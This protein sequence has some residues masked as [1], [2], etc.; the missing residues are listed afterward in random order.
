MGARP[1]AMRM[2]GAYR[3]N[4]SKDDDDPDWEVVVGRLKK[5]SNER[6]SKEEKLRVSNYMT[7]QNIDSKN[8]F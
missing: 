2:L 4:L 1:E 8:I 6:V 3:N 7:I 5:G